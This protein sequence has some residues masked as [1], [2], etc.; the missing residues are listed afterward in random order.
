M[1]LPMD[2]GFIPALKVS[3][4]NSLPFSF[5]YSFFLSN[6]FLIFY[7]RSLL[8]FYLKI[9]VPIIYHNFSPTYFLESYTFFTRFITYW[10]PNF[11]KIKSP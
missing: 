11:K 8:I 3:K 2:F 9:Y 6:I 5:N 7:T 4:L 1:P 10:A